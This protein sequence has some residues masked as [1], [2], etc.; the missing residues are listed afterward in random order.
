MTPT[1]NRTA[2]KRRHEATTPQ[3]HHSADSPLSAR[4]QRQSNTEQPDDDVILWQTLS[5]SGTLKRVLR[6]RMHPAQKDILADSETLTHGIVQQIIESRNIDPLQRSNTDSNTNDN[7]NGDDGGFPDKWRLPP[8]PLPMRGSSGI[9]STADSSDDLTNELG[10]MLRGGELSQEVTPV[11]QR[12][13]RAISRPLTISRSDRDFDKRLLLSSLLLTRP[14][15]SASPSSPMMVSPMYDAA[16]AVR[17]GSPEPLSRSAVQSARKYACGVKAEPGTSEPGNKEAT[18]SSPMQTTQL[19]NTEDSNEI[20]TFGSMLGNDRVST[21]SAATFEH[22]D[23]TC[24]KAE[25]TSTPAEST[26]CES[27]LALATTVATDTTCATCTTDSAANNDDAD[28]QLDDIDMDGLMDDLDGL[29]GFD[30]LEGIDDLLQDTDVEAQ[31]QSS[32]ID[33][34]TD[35]T[36][37]Y[38]EKCLALFVTTGHYT[39]QQLDAPAGTSGARLQKVVRVY[40]QTA[41]RERNVYLRDDWYTTPIGIGDYLNLVG[42]IPETGPDGAVVLSYQALDLLLVLH[43]DTLVS[44]THLADAF[45]CVRR[46]VLKDRIREIS[47]GSPPNTVMLIGQLLHDLFQSCALKNRWDDKTMSDSINTLI[48]DNI[49]SLWECQI[50]E[51]SVHKQISECIPIYQDWAARYMHG[52]AANGSYYSAPANN[53]I[54]S[55]KPS[56]VAD[57][58]TV[59]LAKILNVEENVWSPKFGLKGK[60]DLTVQAQYLP[61]K[62]LV[63]PFELKTGRWTTSTSHRAQLVLYTL[64]M[65]DRFGIDINAGLLYYPR[66]AELIQVPRVATELRGLFITRNDMT[67]YLKHSTQVSRPLPAMVGDDYKCSRCAHRPT[68]FISHRALENGT[69]E[70]ARINSASWE[71]QVGHLSEAH[72]EFVRKWMALIDGEE[73]DMQRFRAELWMMRSDYRELHTGR[74]LADMQIVV[75]SVEDSKTLGSYNRY[76]IAFVP[77]P[78][79]AATRRSLLDSQINVG[80]PISVS[81]ECGQYALAVGYVFSLEYNRVVV[82]VDRPVRGVPKRLAGFDDASNQV[83][84]SLLEIRPH[85]ASARG[86]ETIIY[87]DVPESTSRDRFRIDKDEMS[88]GMSRIRANVMRLFVAEGGDEKWR[89]LV[90]DLEAPTFRPLHP[91]IEAKVLR[92]QQEKQLNTGQADVLRKVLAANDYALVMGMPGTGKTTTIAELVGVLVGQGKSV[93]LASYTHVAVDNILLKLQ[94]REIPM[95]RLGNPNKVHAR[96]VQHLLSEANLQT[97]QQIDG[98][99]RKA[100]VVATTCLGMGHP[101]F[102]MRKFDYC[103]IDEASQITLPVCLGPLLEASKFVLVGDHHQLPPLVRNVGARDGGLGT[104]LFKRLCE[105]HPSAVVRLEYQYRMNADIQRLANNLIYDGH[106]RCGS[107]AVAKQRINYK[108]DPAAA[109][110]GW[111]FAVK[112]P[113]GMAANAAVHVGW[114]ISALDPGRGAVFIDTDCIPGTESRAEGTDVAQNDV[115]IRVIR[116]LTDILQACGIE[117][118]HVGL[119]SPYRTQLKQLEIEYGIRCTEAG[120]KDPTGPSCAQVAVS[121]ISD[122]T[123]A[124]RY[125]G[126]EMHTIDRYQGRDADVVIISFVRSNVGQAIGDLLRDWHRI[127][128]AITRAR[129]KLIMVGSRSTLQRSPLLGGLIKILAKDNCVVQIPST[130]LIPAVTA[131]SSVSGRDRTV[132]STRTA[133]TAGSALLKKMPITANIIAE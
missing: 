64:L 83:Y 106:L 133:T 43:P 86:E 27:D 104:S 10:M 24:T 93:L 66:T 56:S 119:L 125:S 39:Q 36:F 85:G 40:S 3:R 79:S 21:T 80:D 13:M 71:A 26:K 25:S 28:L 69:E 127:N 35:H 57:M 6:Q 55:G 46:A 117:G 38:F 101:I 99:F 34:S 65:S 115:E 88:S 95:V 47:D 84:E 77:A 109:V 20:D 91:S 74:C 126:I 11:A 14:D 108:I 1:K 70:T 124:S 131:A 75:D 62:S 42:N 41:R 73:S 98:F 29:E 89:K 94:D 110:D 82:V 128:V 8:P 100:L 122:N 90:V 68:C 22:S 16:A 52:S 113:A 129:Y 123:Q 45:Y 48:K 103:I 81:T 102:T 9:L 112:R 63:Q 111:P 4:I 118:R 59:A 61:G 17:Q 44:C 49:E 31:A 54:R 130:A 107:L 96:V 105:A 67:Q 19:E 58:D 114:A 37:S 12:R 32:T 78:E 121:G 33:T 76:K 53:M 51:D 60:V 120:S 18:N 5:P 97:V 72:L 50:D 2:Q 23:T 7:Y 132:K 92:V 116:V 30:P 87:P 15:S